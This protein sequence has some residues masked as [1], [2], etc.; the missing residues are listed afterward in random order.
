VVIHPQVPHAPI[1]PAGH[2]LSRIVGGGIIH[3][4]NLVGAAASSCTNSATTRVLLS[5][6]RHFFRGHDRFSSQNR[7]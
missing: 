6:G 7:V 4:Q 5:H 3:D 1:R 2:N